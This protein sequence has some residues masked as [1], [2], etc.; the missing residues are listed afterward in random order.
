MKRGT[1]VEVIAKVFSSTNGP[2]N[3]PV[4]GI[5]HG[6][7]GRD[8]T[9]VQLFDGSM[10]QVQNEFVK[11]REPA[12]ELESRVLLKKRER[13]QLFPAP[14][15]DAAP[16]VVEDPDV[17]TARREMEAEQRAEAEAEERA[18]VA[19]EEHDERQGKLSDTGDGWGPWHQSGIPDPDHSR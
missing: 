19:R 18:R 17:I 10:A 14:D 13:F 4:K 12:D 6:P 7:A 9:S 1:Y 5:V 3:G 15:R 11:E 16:V 2:L 8:S